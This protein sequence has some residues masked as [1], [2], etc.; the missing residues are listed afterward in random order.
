M[1]AVSAQT[2]RPAVP[3]ETFESEGMRLAVEEILKIDNVIW[4]MDFLDG[5]T[6]I[7]TERVGQLNLMDL[8]DFSV[9]RIDGVPE[10]FQ[11][12]SGGLFDVMV[13]PNFGEN[14]FIYLTYVKPIGDGS[15]T[16]AA[17][18]RLRGH[19]LTDLE[20]LF[21][22][23]NASAEA[24]H[25]GSRVVLDHERYLYITVGDRHVPDNAQN[26]ASHGGKVIRLH[27]DGRVPDDNPFVDRTDAAPEVWSYGHRN[28][29]GLTVQ[30]DTGMVI[31]QEHGPTGGDEINIIMRG[32]NYGWPV[33]TYGENIWGGQKAE[34]T[35]KPGMEEPFRYFV[36]SIAP[37]GMTFY[38]GDQFPEWRGNLLNGSLRGKIVRLTLEGQ[39]VTGEERLF[40]NSW[41]RIRDVAQG[42][43]GLLYFATEAG[44]IYR[45]VPISP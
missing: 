37:A 32:A 14:R 29:Q 12:A 17:R 4:A 43:D 34:G 5:N 6:M 8:E 45:I 21:V 40:P 25:W 33:V 10:T 26:L 31:E 15:A 20:E 11:S 24:A 19:E 2:W 3:P 9:T 28:P 36:P 35:S 18:G 16:A 22:A 1:T 30:P 39:S 7:F 44:R 41:E 13:D 23:N 38:T 42:P 27:E